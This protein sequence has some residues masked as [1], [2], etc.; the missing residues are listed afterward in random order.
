VNGYARVSRHN[1]G[2]IDCATW[3]EP[4]IDEWLAA[5]RL[6][7]SR[8]LGRRRPRAT[9]QIRRLAEDF[10]ICFAAQHSGGRSQSLLE[11]LS[12]PWSTPMNNGTARWWLT[13]GPRGRIVV[14]P[15]NQQSD[16]TN[17]SVEYV[18]PDPMAF[19]AEAVAS[20]RHT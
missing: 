19:L 2:S 8:R 10:E 12:I 18:P 16:G 3:L 11:F 1:H 9:A 13:R 7:R 17:T 15:L 6:H 20:A 4:L 14:G 5:I